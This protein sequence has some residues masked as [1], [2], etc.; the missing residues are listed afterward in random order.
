MI[1]SPL[2]LLFAFFFFFAAVVV[3]NAEDLNFSILHTS[4]EHSSLLPTPLSNYLPGQSSPT[5]GGFARLATFVERFKKARASEP[6]LLLSSGDF[7]GGNPFAWLSL[8]GCSPEL[9]LM[10]KIGYD[11]ITL[12]NHEFDYGPEILA[13][14]LQ[15]ARN[16]PPGPAFICSN[17]VAPASHPITVAGVKPNLVLHL[18]NGLKIGIMAIFGKGAHRLAPLAKPLDFSDQHAAAARE[19]ASLKAGGAE[20]IIALT[21]AG[22]YEDIDLAKAVPG[23]HLILGGHDHV[24]LDEPRRVGKTILMHNGS[25][26]QSAGCLELAFNRSD[27]RLNLRN[28]Q[29]GTPFLQR[30][31]SEIPENPVISE[32]IAGHVD[33]LN[34]MVASFTSGKVADLSLPAARLPYP[35]IK[36]ERLCETAIG[37][38]TTDAIRHAAARM[39]GEHVDFAMHAN[40]IIRGDLIPSSLPGRGGEITLFD[41][42]TTCGLGAGQDMQPGYPLVSFYLTGAEILNMLEVATL[43][44]I[45]WNDVYFLQF[46]GLRYWVDPNRAVWF[47]IPWL[48][49]PLPAYRSI[50]AAERYTGHGLQNDTD[51][52]PI[53]AD[54]DRLFHVATT[55][56]MASYLPMVGKR[57]PKLNIVL[58]DKNG[59]PVELDQTIIRQSGREYKLWQA[60]I[61]FTAS[62]ATDST[63]LPLIPDYYRSYGNRI[64]K[65]EGPSLWFWP[66]TIFAIIVLAVTIWLKRRRV[67][68]ARVIPEPPATFN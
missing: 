50:L 8:N 64:V 16:S 24:A 65:T 11:A 17:L 15:N 58:K 7:T 53:T 14:L 35:I 54:H 66:C 13:R 4:D 29:T 41:L 55:H 56:Y 51:Y 12:G 31:D 60:A 38:F 48:N 20:V 40:G 43:L 39:T 68:A 46:S 61:D 32:K 21:H 33:A 49:K 2:R 1:K 25:Y 37:N 67:N 9:D 22:Y 52:E 30:L 36:H 5:L 10:S 27:S 34:Q 26:L 3:G 19:I 62:F 45:I 42:V 47:N 57:L 23:I 6:V 63:G 18:D 59:R 44:P 28:H